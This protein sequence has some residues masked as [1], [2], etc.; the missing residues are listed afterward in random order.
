MGSYS[1]VKKCDV[2]ATEQQM[3]SEGLGTTSIRLWL[4]FQVQG[5]E[6][7]ETRPCVEVSDATL[8]N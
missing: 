4:E 5:N 7:R 8:R 1:R 6:W 2:P 3:S